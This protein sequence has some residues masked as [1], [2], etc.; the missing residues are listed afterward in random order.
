MRSAIFVAAGIILACMAPARAD[1]NELPV[2]HAVPCIEKCADSSEAVGISRP[3][4]KFP[5]K[6]SSRITYI[7]GDVRLH[8]KIG[9]DGHVS[10]I[11]VLEAIGPQDF[12]DLATD[13]V[14][15]WIYK[16]ATL[17]GSPVETCHVMEIRFVISKA[18][19]GARPEIIKSYDAA[20]EEIRNGKWD[21]AQAVLTDAMTQPKINLYEYGMLGNA[22]SIVALHR[23]DMVE[24]KRISEKA[25]YLGDDRLPETVRRTLLETHAQSAVM[26]GDLP[27]ALWA[28]EQLKTI[29]GRVEDPVVGFVKQ[30]RA[31]LDTAPV[32]ATTERIPDTGQA[33]TVVELYRRHFAFADIKGGLD[34]F[35]LSCKQKAIESKI[36]ET[37]EWH[38]PPDWSE[39]H[40]LIYGQ[41]GTSFRIAQGLDPA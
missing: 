15:D 13:A 25:Y 33:V 3:L 9:V 20:V 2:I 7:E 10:D 29:K 37:A 40:L 12:I 19:A 39:C 17:N 6:Y 38:V 14:K 21:D 4:P 23:N 31:K 22:Q 35:T 16:P 11:A 27:A 1:N 34:R 24:A 41:A 30:A 26:T 36:S 8:Y 32:I 18:P 5:A 28:V